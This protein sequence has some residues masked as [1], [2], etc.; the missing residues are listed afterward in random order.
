[1]K[2]DIKLIDLVIELVDARIP[3]ASRNPDIDSLASGRGRVL[4]LGKSD[5]ADPGET[6]KWISFF[7]KQDIYAVAMDSR[8]KKSMK[9]LRTQIDKASEKKRERD[10]KKGIKNRPVRAL[11]AGI[12]N[13]GK[14]TL[15]NTL[16]GRAS[17]KTGNKP[18]V[19]KGKQWI[20][21]GGDIELLD[22]PGL[23]WPKFEDK[24][25]GFLLASVGTINEDIL[26]REEMAIELYHRLAV[27]YPGRITERYGIKEDLGDAEVLTNIAL[28][29]GFLLKDSEP[30]IVRASRLFLDEVRGGML[31]RISLEEIKNE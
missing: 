13:I 15:I 26:P 2:E 31:G 17:A 1:M 23:L 16:A 5:L 11:V 25:V 12:P 18:G 7:S 8:D 21:L 14:S 3:L 10:R 9:A 6:E 30:D 29:R 20:R 19:T 4:V 28:K 24:E 22:T 27:K